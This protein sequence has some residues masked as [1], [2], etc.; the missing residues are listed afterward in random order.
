MLVATNYS[1][2]CENPDD[3]V[4]DDYDNTNDGG[5]IV[6]GDDDDED[7][8]ILR[9]LLMMMMKMMVMVVMIM[10]VKGRMITMTAMMKMKI[11]DDADFVDNSESQSVIIVTLAIMSMQNYPSISFR[12]TTISI[13]YVIVFVL[14]LG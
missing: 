13:I 7:D 2:P 12:Y 3:D 11:F 5:D 14:L 9:G 6:N 1:N 4:I 10:M 8:A